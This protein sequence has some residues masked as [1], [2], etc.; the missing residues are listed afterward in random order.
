MALTT[1]SFYL[2]EEPNQ[3]NCR[4]N[5]EKIQ[6]P[7]VFV[8]YLLTLSDLL[9]LRKT[10]NQIHVLLCRDTM[11]FTA[12][13]LVCGGMAT[14]YESNRQQFLSDLPSEIVLGFVVHVHYFDS[15]V[16]LVLV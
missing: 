1:G 9:V 5:E 2:T 14:V 11:N 12:D 13:M 6:R 15:R 16:L 3:E 4:G 10:P 8:L 7:L